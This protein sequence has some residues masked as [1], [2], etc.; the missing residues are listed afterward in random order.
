MRTMACPQVPSPS[1]IADPGALSDRVTIIVEADD[2][3][4]DGFRDV[5]DRDLR[6]RDRHFM[7]ESE[8]VV[9]RLLDT[10]DAVAAVLMT[11]PHLERLADR[12]AALPDHV[13]IY[14][15][16][17]D[18]MTHLAGFHIHRG[19]LA[20]GHR[21]R[22]HAL[23]LDAALGHLRGRSGLRLLVA[24]GVTNVDNMGALFRNAAAFGAD[25][26]VLDPD[27]CDPLYRKALRVSVGHTLSVPWA[28]AEP[29]PAALDR[30]RAEWGCAIIGAE[31]TPEAV[32]LWEAGARGGGATGGPRVPAGPGSGRSGTAPRPGVA[33]VFGSEAHGLSAEAMARC[34][35]T[36]C[37]PMSGNVPSLNVAVA[38]A[39]F[40][41]EWARREHHARSHDPTPPVV[42]DRAPAVPV[43]HCP[44]PA[45]APESSS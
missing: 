15:A 23:T 9:T 39:L 13:P 4:L 35:Q 7:A 24:E 6:G 43:E 17:L 22:R 25:G 36:A 2:A 10:P 14:G 37:I 1:R 31:V 44:A 32:P 19:V 27:C 45:G 40:L 34:D 33:F 16:P 29:W 26:I 8:L 30:L 12:I 20:L 38:S 21:P 11:P 18:V 28:I 3:R 41:A 42:V 5:R